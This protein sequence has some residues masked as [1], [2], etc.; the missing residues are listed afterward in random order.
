MIEV[1]DCNNSVITPALAPT[2]SLDMVTTGANWS[3]QWSIFGWS[4]PLCPVD[5]YSVACTEGLANE[6][7]GFCSGFQ[8]NLDASVSSIKQVGGGSFGPRTILAQ[9]N[10]EI[11]YIKSDHEGEF[12]F[13][14]TGWFH[15]TTEHTSSMAQ[16][17]V[18][19]TTPCDSPLSNVTAAKQEFQGDCR[20][21]TSGGITKNICDDIHYTVFTY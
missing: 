11:G 16:F 4:D 5:R 12:S 7:T 15:T 10:N 1:Y 17:T 8:I 14:I 18:K 21:K 6:N 20:Q 9:Y 3:Y 13:V 19:A 2:S